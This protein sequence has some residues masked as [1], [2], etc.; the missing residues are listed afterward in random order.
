M[1]A[2]TAVISMLIFIYVDPNSVSSPSFGIMADLLAAARLSV[3]LA[4]ILSSILGRLES[5]RLTT[6]KPIQLN[7]IEVITS[8][9]LKRA[10]QTPGKAPQIIP[11]SIEARRA[12]HHGI[13]RIIPAYRAKN[14]P[15]VYCP[16]APMLKS[17][18]L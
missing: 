11:P 4:D 9:T 5:D 3:R 16:E 1:T 8:L 7:M 2:M 10:L 6:N 13:L 17:P 14:A 18:V 15:M 12:A